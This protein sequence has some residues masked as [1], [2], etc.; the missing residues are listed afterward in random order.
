MMLPWTQ[1]IRA[2]GK[3][4][5]LDPS[6]RPQ[7]IYS[8][9]GGRI[10]RWYVREGD[11]VRKGDTIA[12]LSEIKSDY[13]D[14]DLLD[15]TKLQV[16]AKEMS[17]KSYESKADALAGQLSALQE[18][19]KL[20]LEQA[21]NKIQQSR[22]KI[23][24]DSIEL[25]AAKIDYS[26]AA[27]QL[28][29]TDSMYRSGIKSLTDLEEKRKKA[30]ETLAK[31]IAYENKVLIS[32]NELLNAQIELGSITNDYADKIAKSQSEQFSTLSSLYDA[33]GS[34]AKLNNQY[35]NY[36]VR[37]QF[38]YVLAPQD[39]Y[40]SKILKKGLGEVIKENDELVQIM[41]KDFQDD[42]CVE[43]YIEP[44]DYPLLQV[45]QTVRFIFD[46][47][48]AFVF[49]GWPDQ[50]FGTFGGQVYAIDNM[51]QENGK[52]RILVIPA[53]K[54]GWPKALR[55]GTGADGM[56]LLNDVP[57]WYELWRQLNGFPPNFYEPVEY[58]DDKLKLKAPANH[59]K[60]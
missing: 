29:R 25:E 45:G 8:T 47:W 40:V 17:V 24:S 34:V 31:K 15:R 55:V 50:S 13:F 5:T 57:L 33:Q 21:V 16:K 12:F 27:A 11:T 52:Y 39:G 41:P 9:I 7:S 14:P 32:R 26:I 35:S 3:I 44:M 6:H 10:E 19:R 49:S 2:K 23:M 43:M 20:K 4:T 59:L 18:A 58:S 53:D 38:Y 42:L 46:G 60:K 48:P 22:L 30:Q 51:T 56:I 28:I 36:E 1:N 54:K 37:S